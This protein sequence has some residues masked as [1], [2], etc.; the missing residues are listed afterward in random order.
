M[1][2]FPRKHFVRFLITV[3]CTATVVAL[4][5]SGFAL[6]ELFE[7]KS[8]DLRF[9]SRGSLPTSGKVVMAVIDE[10]SLAHEG[11][12]PWPRVK[13][14]KLIEQLSGDGARVIGLDIGFLE[15]DK[16]SHLKLIDELEQE[17]SHTRLL[18]PEVKENL[19]QRRALADNDRLLAKAIQRSEASIVLGYFFHMDTATIDSNDGNVSP[20]LHQ[21]LIQS[22]K[23]P[24]V[25]MTGASPSDL[26]VPTAA[27]VQPNI[28]PLVKAAR[29]S[30]FFNKL[31][32]TDGIV[33]TTPLVIRYQEDLYAALAVQA[34]WHYLDRPT[35]SVSGATHGVTHIQ[36]GPLKIPTNEFGH[37]LVNHLGSTEVLPY[38]SATDIIN[39]HFPADTF[40][41]RIVL[42]GGAAM[43]IADYIITPF[44]PVAPGLTLHATVVENILSG[45]FLE[46]PRWTIIFDLAAVI[47]IGLA[48]GFF[49][50]RMSAV[51]G[52]LA[53]LGLFAGYLLFN[54]WL[55]IEHGVWLG[56]IY[57]VAALVLVYLAQ[58]L[59]HYFT[60]TKER[61]RV[62]N[63]FQQYLSGDVIDQMLAN[64][65][66]LQL[67]GIVKNLTILFSDLEGFTS[68]AENYKPD[69]LVPLLN[70]YFSQMTEE[71]FRH[72]GTLLE[73]LGDGMLV[74]FGAPLERR[75]H[76]T[77]AVRAAMA[78]QTRLRSL[79]R[80]W[81]QPDSPYHDPW[82]AMGSPT[83]FTRFG[84][85]SGD[86]LV[87][88][89]GSRQ[90]FSY[91]VLGDEVNLASRIEGLNK[92]YGTRILVGQNSVHQVDKSLTL[93]EIDQVRVMGKK[94][95]IRI[96]EPVFTASAD[97][98]LTIEQQ[99]FIT[100]Y[101]SGLKAYRK[102]Q[103]PEAITHF[104][105]AGKL[106]PHDHSWH[107]MRNRC[108]EL[109]TTSPDENWDG[110]YIAT[111]K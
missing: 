32:D 38:Y 54:R 60:E 110:V 102:Q 15:P 40:K 48:A 39:G 109:E 8:Y 25:R 3:V 14:A 6:F 10:K 104:E 44:S 56:I 28:A 67:G 27:A 108:Q 89:L 62:K 80:E 1:H 35:L 7:L 29:G 81:A 43:G 99:Q 71:I 66:Q 46:K 57:P 64:P 30:G 106:N 100:T 59:F 5:F 24:L 68:Y 69:E 83:L 13:M 91:S 77:D 103:W 111:K 101:H 92:Q 17:L 21:Q 65:D 26:P 4:F 97:G 34:V 105:Q 19:A 90:R 86:V 84:I 88:N 33:R 9:L 50:A 49:T 58:I 95:P 78:M 74:L 31:S 2:L 37:L 45:R 75:D 55:F 22:A 52:L 16:N 47:F 18:S 20:R 85:N 70:E 53:N 42:V 87:G 12:W 36:M 79:Q 82:K 93:R 76:A 72:H 61:R 107:V 73:F 51:Y 63:T 94:L 23:Y 41:D 96:F 98:S 11:R